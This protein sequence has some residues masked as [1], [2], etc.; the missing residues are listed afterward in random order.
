MSSEMTQHFAYEEN[1]N[2]I[3]VI[4]C[5]SYDDTAV[6]PEM[7]EGKPV[8]AL[9]PYVF[10][11]HMEKAPVSETAPALCGERVRKICLPSSL[12]TIGR[13]AFYNCSQLRE[14]SF[15]SGLKNLGAGIFTGCHKVH[16]LQIQ[17]HREE[18]S[19]LKEVLSE[20][21]EELQ[22]TIHK[23]ADAV[24]MFPEFFEEG[25]ENT[26][27]RILE[28]RIHGSGLFYRNCFQQKKLD[29]REYD[30]RFDQ[31]RVLESRE[32]LIRLVLGRLQ[33]PLELSEKYKGIYEKYL[34]EEKA[35]FFQYLIGLEDMSQMEWFLQQ[36]RIEKDVLEAAIQELSY[37][38][39]PQILSY[40]MDYRHKYFPAVRQSFDL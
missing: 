3:T 30:A 33:Y 28:T 4:R 40:L 14:I 13:Y 18:T 7:I 12:E 10:S 8:T 6:I 34:E 36:Y 17:F 25:V 26:P 1:K 35:A 5:F 22:V 11:V 31:A 19:C 29:I 37:Q 9:A 15:H 24:L 32:F 16:K 20:L 38:N 23:E 21:P 2:G 27:A 39:K